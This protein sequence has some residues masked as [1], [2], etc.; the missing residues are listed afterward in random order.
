MPA[1]IPT[2]TPTPPPTPD[3]AQSAPG[4]TPD[5]ASALTPPELCTVMT[6]PVPDPVPIDLADP[7]TPCTTDSEGAAADVTNPGQTGTE[8][9]VDG[10]VTPAD[11]ITTSAVPLR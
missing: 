1:P 11:H 4:T 2:P 9:T 5:P 8:A 6:H 7:T 10:D 3:P